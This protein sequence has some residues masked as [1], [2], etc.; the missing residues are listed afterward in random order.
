MLYIYIYKLD[1]KQLDE[2]MSDNLKGLKILHSWR[3]LVM[4]IFYQ[5]ALNLLEIDEFEIRSIGNFIV[6]SI[7]SKIW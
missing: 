3:K 2:F 6:F 7:S 1:R 4:I 5:F